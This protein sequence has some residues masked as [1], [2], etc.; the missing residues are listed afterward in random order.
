[1][2]YQVNVHPCRHSLYVVSSESLLVVVRKS[3][4]SIAEGFSMLPAIARHGILT[5]LIVESM[6]N[7][8]IYLDCIQLCLTKMN[9]LLAD[10]FVL[11]MN[12]CPIHMSVKVQEMAEVGYM[13]HTFQ[14]QPTELLHGYVYTF[15]CT[16]LT[17]TSLS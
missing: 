16:D 10:N 11:I 9:L 5:I 7:T 14:Y 6:L 12:N 3:C 1:M 4:Q 8:Q 17:S 2:H 13:T 15:H